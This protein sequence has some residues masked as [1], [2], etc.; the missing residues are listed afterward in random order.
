MVI[1]GLQLKSLQGL[2]HKLLSRGKALGSCFFV[3]VGLKLVDWSSAEV[4]M[5]SSKVRDIKLLSRGKALGSC[6]LVTVSLK[7]V[8]G[9]SAGVLKSSKFES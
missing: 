6:I 1:V 3:I 2:R 5:K 7:L 4:L 8:D 9:S